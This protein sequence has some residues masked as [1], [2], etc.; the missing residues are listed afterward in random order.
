[1]NSYQRGIVVAVILAVLT[2]LEY[3]FAVE[4]DNTSVRFL[5]LAIT[6]LLK[7]WL[8]IQYFMHIARAW[9]KQGAH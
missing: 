9:K 5:G 3:I 6:A 2:V 8:I 1:M 7:S 4:V